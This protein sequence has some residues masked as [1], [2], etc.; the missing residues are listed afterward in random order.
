MQPGQP[1]DGVAESFEMLHV[2]RR[3]HRD[4]VA[5]DVDDVVV[6]FRI[7]AARSVAVRELVDEH[8]ARL[9]AQHGVAIEFSVGQARQQFDAC[10]FGR[11]VEPAVRF[12]ERADD[13]DAF[14][15][16]R[17]GPV[18]HREGL[19]A[20]GDR[21]QIDRQSAIADAQPVAGGL[22]VRMARAAISAG[23][24]QPQRI[25]D[26]QVAV[27]RAR[28]DFGRHLAG[29]HAHERRPHGG[30]VALTEIGRQR[31]HDAVA[32]AHRLDGFSAGFPIDE[33]DFEG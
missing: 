31:D 21:A 13:V 19:A 9:A 14:F 2:E 11:R 23:Q 5:Q 17:M 6:A 28:Q 15:H 26:I 7:R 16:Q 30:Q 12:D 27:Q 22:T 10:G 8:D 32:G 33:S 25:D 3:H 1:L 24:R 29:R 18:E 20:A 4:P